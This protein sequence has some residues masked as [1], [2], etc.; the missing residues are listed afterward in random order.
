M[1]M[2]SDMFFPPA[3]CQTEWRLIPNAA[4]RPIQ[5]VDGHLALFGVDPNAIAQIDKHLR[6]LLASKFRRSR[7]RGNDGEAHCPAS[8]YP[9]GFSGIYCHAASRKRFVARLNRKM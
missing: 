5:T 2:S 6:D 3:D 9:C 4:F 8:Q 7:L 1:P